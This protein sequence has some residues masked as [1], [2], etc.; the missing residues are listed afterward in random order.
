M[1]LYFDSHSENLQ[2]TAPPNS[3]MFSEELKQKASIK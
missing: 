3:T 2:I 1:E